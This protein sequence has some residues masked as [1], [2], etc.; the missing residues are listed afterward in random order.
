VSAVRFL[1]HL[2]TLPR[3][4]GHFVVGHTPR[5]VRLRNHLFTMI[6]LTLIVD[7]IASW[8]MWRAERTVLILPANGNGSGIDPNWA[9]V[10][11]YWDAAFFTTCQLLTVSSLF[12]S[13]YS[14]AGRILNIFLEMWGITIVAA[15]A[16]AFGAF[17]LAG[18]QER[19]QA[20]TSYVADL[21]PETIEA[22]EEDDDGGRGR[23]PPPE[24][25]PG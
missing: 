3:H 9:H 13:P 19:E 12:N 15:L 6:V 20:A 21:A 11:D 5:H 18:R 17:F 25:A 24:P 4:L 7:A 10:R 22:Q 8:A 1:A 16:G 23:V 14:T 2:I